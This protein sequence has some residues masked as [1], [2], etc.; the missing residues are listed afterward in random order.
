MV[1]TYIVPCWYDSFEKPSYSRFLFND[2]LYHFS[3]ILTFIIVGKMHPWPTSNE[4][5]WQPS[6]HRWVEVAVLIFTD[7]QPTGCSTGKPSR[8][9][10]STS[11]ADLLMTLGTSWSTVAREK[12]RDWVLTVWTSAFTSGVGTQP[13]TL[14]CRNSLLS[15]PLLRVFSPSDTKNTTALV[16]APNPDG[17]PDQAGRACAALLH[18][19]APSASGRR[20]GEWR[21]RGDTPDHHHNSTRTTAGTPKNSWEVW[22]G[23]VQWTIR[24]AE[25]EFQQTICKVS[26]GGLSKYS[27][28]VSCDS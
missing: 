20:W 16:C 23:D 11:S 7:L 21:E 25:L 8:E 24:K 3:S 28:T 19:E 5:R 27:D 15:K 17:G 2:A 9:R 6:S 10:Y 18:H 12:E 14:R 1:Q 4:C 22:K 13:S 26:V